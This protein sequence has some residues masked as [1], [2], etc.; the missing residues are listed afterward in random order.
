MH[1]Q[2]HGV[3]VVVVFIPLVQLNPLDVVCKLG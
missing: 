2:E 1:L 3:E